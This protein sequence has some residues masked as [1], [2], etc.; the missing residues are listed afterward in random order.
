MPRV[1]VIVPAYN[2]AEH[3]GATLQSVVAQTY[4]DWEAVV[5]DDAST[6]DTATRAA[7]VDPR[8]RVVRAE[9]NAGPAATRNLAIAN[10]TGEL[11]AFLDAD[12]AWEPDFLEEMVGLYDRQIAGRR[13]VGIVACDAR[14]VGP[15]GA[16][17]Y[18]HSE[19]TGASGTPD[20]ETLL[21]GNVIYVSALV[22]RAIVEEVGGFSTETWGSED[23]DLWIRILEQGYEVA[24]IPRTLATYRELDGSVSSSAAAMARTNQATYRRA[25]ARG[26]LT[27]RQQRLARRSLRLQLAIEELEAVAARRAS[28]ERLRPRDLATA[29]RAAG[30]FALFALRHPS[31]WGRWARMLA[32]GAR[33]PW[34]AR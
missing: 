25:L 17:R 34:R 33:T 5:A 20:L 12:D 6:D 30:T 3:I 13:R 11:L 24:R 2:A 4:G 16:L 14:I 26:R 9:E 22:P 28:V 18:T 21:D 29:A 31:R 32:G 19:R 1:S 8:V 23:H 27:P 10:A 15:D 7:A